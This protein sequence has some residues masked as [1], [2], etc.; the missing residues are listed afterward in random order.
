MTIAAVNRYIQL[1]SSAFTALGCNVPLREVEQ[2]SMLVHSTMEQPRRVYHSS[3]H[4]FQLT[5]SMGPRQVLGVLFHDLVYVQLDDGF[6]RAMS[7]NLSGVVEQRGN[8]WLLLPQAED[9]RGMQLCMDLFGFHPGQHI[10]LFGGLNEFL[11]AVAAVRALE[12]W[13]SWEDLSAIV[14]AIEC[15]VPFRPRCADGLEVAEAL[16]QRLQRHARKWGMDL[17]EQKMLAMVHQ[18][19]ELGNRDVGGFADSD[20]SNFLSNTWQLM[21]ESNAPL[22]AV[23]VYT[24]SDYRQVLTRT[25]GFLRSLDPDAIFHRYRNL[26]D[27]KTFNR[28]RRNARHNLTFSS[29]YIDA[30]IATIA[31]IEGL[32]RATGGDGPISMFLGDIRSPLG[33]PDRVEDFLPEPV[34]HEDIQPDLLEIFQEGRSSEANHDLTASPLTAFVYRS[35]GHQGTLRLLFDAQSMFDGGVEAMAFLHK[36]P[37]T[38][39][40]PV[41]LACARIALS[42]ADKLKAIAEAC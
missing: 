37:P 8:D 27:E 33:R 41:A 32:A 36:L 38:L 11:S 25:S 28:L 12:P 34:E 24:L 13:V 7:D 6:P 42:R 26:P 22:K 9:D 23:G 19:V 4:V 10:G 29:D 17:P 20:P 39:V 18:A 15:T 14:A 21:D 31:L 2:L 1:F 16:A 35:L 30:K 40:K 5:E 3:K